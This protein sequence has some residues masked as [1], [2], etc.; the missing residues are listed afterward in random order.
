MSVYTLF[1]DSYLDGIFLIVAAGDTAT[2]LLEGRKSFE[3][4][5]R[6]SGGRGDVAWQH[7][8]LFRQSLNSN[9]YNFVVN[10]TLKN[11]KNM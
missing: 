7:A 6:L 2:N 3:I 9:D 11:E 1:T 4:V 5:T 10:I 8:Q